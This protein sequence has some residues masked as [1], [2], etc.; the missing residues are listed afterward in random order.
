M[1]RID[2]IELMDLLDSPLLISIFQLHV[3]I[4][5]ALLYSAIASRYFP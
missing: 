5:N 1:Q 2:S 4:P 3:D